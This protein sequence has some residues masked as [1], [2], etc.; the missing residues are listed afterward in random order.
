[1]T[2]GRIELDRCPAC[3]SHDIGRVGRLNYFCRNCFTQT[4]NTRFGLKTSFIDRNGCLCD[5]TPAV[6]E[7]LPIRAVAKTLNQPYKRLK[8]FVREK[9]VKVRSDRGGNLILNIKEVEALIYKEAYER[10]QTI[11]GQ[12]ANRPKPTTSLITNHKHYNTGET[13]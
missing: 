3:G 2:N 9:K 5:K 13:N 6:A 4:H 7:W 10:L 12:S 11:K 8:R 1:M